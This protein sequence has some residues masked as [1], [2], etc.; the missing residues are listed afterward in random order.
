ML[1]LDFVRSTVNGSGAYQRLTHFSVYPGCKAS[2]PVVS[3]DDRFIAFQLAKASEA[4]GVGHDILVLDLENA[5][6]AD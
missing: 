4:A 6:R 3:D 5:P 2:N 1:S